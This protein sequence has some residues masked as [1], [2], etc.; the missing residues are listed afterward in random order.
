MQTVSIF[1]D[2]LVLKY[3]DHLYSILMYQVQKNFMFRDN[4]ILPPKTDFEKKNEKSSRSTIPHSLFYMPGTAVRYS[5]IK[6]KAKKKQKNT[7][8]MLGTTLPLNIRIVWIKHWYKNCHH[9]YFG[10][11]T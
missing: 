8:T 2:R 7:S 3:K 10:E 11:L 1:R 9:F 4:V 5:T 6:K